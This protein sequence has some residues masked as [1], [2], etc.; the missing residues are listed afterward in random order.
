M[1]RTCSVAV[2]RNALAIMGLLTLTST[3]H[4]NEVL[5]SDLS[6]FSLEELASV[7]V[8]AA[9]LLRANLLDA[10]SSIGAV[11]VED[12]QRRGARRLADALET[13]PAIMPLPHAYG[14]PV[15]AI[16]GYARSSSYTGIATTWDGI[17]LN[18]LFRS[19]P[20]FNTSSINLGA[21][22]QIQLIQGP[23]SALY[24]S[25]AFHGVIAL[26]S[27][28]SDHAL[29]Q[30]RVAGGGDGYYEAALQHS[31][32]ILGDNQLHFALAAN[33]QPDQ[34]RRLRFTNPFTNQEQTVE[35]ANKYKAETLSLKLNTDASQKRS[36][37]AGLYLH[38]YDADGGQGAGTRLSGGEDLAWMYSHLAMVQGGV[39][40]RLND[41]RSLE[42][43]SYYWWLDADQTS[44]RQNGQVRRGLVFTEFRGGAQAIYRDAYQ[45]GHTEW[46]LALGQEWLGMTDGVTED[47]TPEG[48][49][50]SSTPLPA[51]D[52]RRKVRSA[53]LEV[54]THWHDQRWRLVYGGRL[55]DYSDFGNHTSPRVGLIYHPHPDSA[56]KLLYGEAFR[57]PS[58]LEIGGAQGS[59]IGN[60]NLKPE[61]IKSYELIALRQTP[62]YLAQITLFRNHWHDGISTVVIAQGSPAQFQNVERNDAHGVTTAVQARLS[63][64]QIDLS[65]SS[66]QS[67]NTRTGVRY[68]IFPRYMLNA[69]IGHE[70]FDPSWQLQLNQRWLSKVDDVPLTGGFPPH[71]L[72]RYA[73]TDVALRKEVSRQ[74][75]ASL[76]LRNLFDRNNRMPSAPAAI[77]GIP[78]ERFSANIAVDYEF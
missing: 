31:Q 61:V 60:P 30:S 36:W 35:R 12:W 29:S 7:D 40:Q 71:T 76:Q 69:G 54:N 74:V 58:A 63:G 44:S 17:P 52:A 5:T 39:K 55:D 50:I 70:L 32:A 28:E 33:G 20:Q 15:F 43:K 64:W 26:R 45:P 42:L 59:A 72:P 21:L 24:G 38:N 6:D 14:N 66:V 56:I 51:D 10:A 41:T 19:A 1:P 48:L 78:D 22:Q 16:R 11:S 23:G 75:N 77:G 47:R 57:A 4:A 18:D 2:R 27:F 34:E 62:R 8:S 53:T 9:S 73:R 13:Q 46:A 65:G 37:Y 25:D 49:L 67:R 3:A 68:N